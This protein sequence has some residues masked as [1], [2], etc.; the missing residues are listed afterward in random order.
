MRGMLLALC[1]VA[2]LLVSSTA[3]AIEQD[4]LST[5]VNYLASKELKGRKPWSKGS[6]LAREYIMEHFK[7]AGLSP[8]GEADGYEQDIYL[9]T[10]VVGVL[11]GTDETLKDQAVLVSAHYDHVGNGCLDACDNA[12]GVAV[13]LE[14]VK[15]FSAHP[16][17]R[18]IIF[19]SFDREENMLFGAYA[20]TCRS[21]YDATKVA[22]V[23]NIDAL[24]R[25]FMGRVHNVL[26]CLGTR[27]YPGVRAN[28]TP[29]GTESSIEVLPIGNEI[30]GL[31][32]DHLAFLDV[33]GPRLFFTGGTY[34]DYHT[35]R[36]TADRLDFDLLTRQANTVASTV[37][38]LADAPAIESAAKSSLTDKAELTTYKRIITEAFAIDAEKVSEED[39]QKR[40]LVL[41]RLD[42]AIANPAFTEGDRRLLFWETVPDLAPLFRR[43]ISRGDDQ[44]DA[45]SW[46]DDYVARTVRSLFEAEPDLVQGAEVYRECVTKVLE[47]R[48]IPLLR[49]LCNLEVS[50]SVLRDEDFYLMPIAEGQFRLCAFMSKVKVNGSLVLFQPH[51]RLCRAHCPID[52]TGS[53]DEI[54]DFCLLRWPK[55][56]S[57][58]FDKEYGQLLERITGENYG[59]KREDWLKA[60]LERRGFADEQAWLKSILTVAN[61]ELVPMALGLS[62]NVMP[63]PDADLTAVM[64]KLAADTSQ[65]ARVRAGAIG[66]CGSLDDPESLLILADILKED[67]Q[68]DMLECNTAESNDP[69]SPL[70]SD[71]RVA[72]TRTMWADPHYKVLAPFKKPILLSDL[73]HQ[74]LKTLMHRYYDKDADTWR[75]SIER[76]ARRLEKRK[77]KEARASEPP[78]NG[79]IVSD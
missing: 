6:R 7:A 19:A 49:P 39:K 35:K 1:L 36:D 62:K 8:W 73:A 24:G 2:L 22:A 37:R 51:G 3:L 14:L 74:R 32:G 43:V 75:A 13:L 25:D 20:F 27:E 34:P 71:Y 30:I 58:F 47:R 79:P 16:G 72:G 17:Q 18:P 23:V 69:T 38:Q 59:D 67:T 40:S 42:E 52:F 5:H 46:P 33:N 50:R 60:E 70:Y 63:A 61:P 45:K 78:V 12:S 76:H 15:E 55:E 53:H 4:A 26:F 48:P 28:I 65:D 11:P 9:G 21:D 54:V 56:P 57:E 44:E 68:L 29:S 10:N 66:L 41:S 77:A 31:A 64:N